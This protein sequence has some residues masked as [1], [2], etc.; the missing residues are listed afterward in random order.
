M[1]KVIVD[2]TP[3]IVFCGIGRLGVLQKLYVKAKVRILTM[4]CVA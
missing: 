3:I 2:F 1:P 4:S